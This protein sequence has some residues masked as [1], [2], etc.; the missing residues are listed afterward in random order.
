MATQHHAQLSL[1]EMGRLLADVTFCVVDLETTGSSPGKGSMITEIGAV[2]VRGG[3]VLG[4]FQTLVDPQTAIPAHVRALTGISQ[5]SVLGA[6][7]ISSALPAFLEFATGSVLVAHNAG[8]DI[9][10]LKHFAAVQEREWPGFEVLDTLTLARRVITKDEAPNCKLGTL[11]RVLGSTTEPN[12]RALSDA[13]ATVDVLHAL[14]ARVGGLGVTTMEDLREYTRAV[15]PA[16]RRKRGL[17]DHLPPSPGV[18]LFRDASD[19]VLYIGTS[20]DLRRRVRTYFTASE[21]RSRMGE[22]IAAATRVEGIECAT[23]LE[24]GVRELRL[25]AA[26]RPPYNRR[27]KFPDKQSWIKLTDEPWPRLSVVKQ[28][29][30]DGATHLGPMSRAAAAR[31]REALEDTHGVRRCTQRLPRTPKGSACVLAELGS[32]HAPC[33]PGGDTDAYLKEVGALRATMRGGAEAVIAWHQERMSQLGEAER[34]EAAAEARD[35]LRTF[36]GAA[37]RSHR[38]ARITACPEV[39]AARREDVGVAGGGTRSLWVVHVIRHGR[40]AGSGRIPPGA[41]AH[42]FVRVLRDSSESVAPPAPHALSASAEE[43]LAVL[44]WLEQPGVRLVHVRG[45]WVSLVD[46]PARHGELHQSLAT[47]AWPPS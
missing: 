33:A 19:R 34:F 44:R 42:E 29:S 3:E 30:A 27:S 39:V 17:G 16:Q 24:A 9:T 5:R 13:R 22:M 23:A 12:H 36:V 18:Y 38:L 37:T 8:F 26:H 20:K 15:S 6:P 4:E 35:R 32:C 43:V 25:I 41:D 21:T 10:F 28:P 7:T 40:L 45:D 31:T 1:T 11:A 46:S 14:L 2:K 47:P